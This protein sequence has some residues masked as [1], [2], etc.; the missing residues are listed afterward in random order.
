M[1]DRNALEQVSVLRRNSTDFASPT[2]TVQTNVDVSTL[3]Q[4]LRDR[5]QLGQAILH[6]CAEISKSM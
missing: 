3:L 2:E 6:I 5:F 4:G 1:Y